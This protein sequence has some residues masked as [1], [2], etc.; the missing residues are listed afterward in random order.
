MNLKASRKPA[1][2]AVDIDALLQDSYL[3]V[4]ELR[5]GASTLDGTALWDLCVKQVEH[6]RQLLEHA[7]LAP[8]SIDHISHAQCALLDETVLRI[9]TQARDAWTKEPLQA[10]FFNRHQA[11]EFLYEDM[12]EV[13][14]EPAPDPLVLTVFHRVLM[15]GFQGRY[16]DA[17]DPE[18][19]QL[20]SAFHVQV[21]PLGLSR[22]LATTVKIGQRLR[23]RLWTHSPLAHGLLVGMLFVG[24]WWGLDQLLA[25][26]LNSVLPGEA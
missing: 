23:M 10:K 5:Q 8:R 22:S 4:V 24:L 7:G 12:R 25:N 13:L 6:V 17:G 1:A 2:L 21:A 18:R 19:E 11:G 20:L 3:L 9:E 26:L 15:L 16:R 14:R